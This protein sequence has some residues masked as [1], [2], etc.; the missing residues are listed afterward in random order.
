MPGLSWQGTLVF[1]ILVL[2]FSAEDTFKITSGKQ[3]DW[4]DA[5][6]VKSPWVSGRA[7]RR[8]PG[9]DGSRSLKAEGWAHAVRAPSAASLLGGPGRWRSRSLGVWSMEQSLKHH[10]PPGLERVPEAKPCDPHHGASD[11]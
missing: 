7:Q 4:S 2:V 1:C 3:R 5:K 10:L 8:S 9:R 11:R 6:S